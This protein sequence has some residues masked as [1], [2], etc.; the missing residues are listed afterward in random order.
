MSISTTTSG[1]LLSPREWGGGHFY[2]HVSGEREGGEGGREGG[3]E[4]GGRGEVKFLGVG[5][6]LTFTIFCYL[7]TNYFFERLLDFEK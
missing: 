2:H 1:T 4:G 3:R 5:D 7:G 6:A